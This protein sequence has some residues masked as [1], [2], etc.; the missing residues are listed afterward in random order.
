MRNEKKIIVQTAIR[1]S[2]KD[3]LEQL[4]AKKGM[5]Q[6]S[7][8]SRLVDWFA[9]QDSM[10]Q[11]LILERVEE[12]DQVQIAKLIL[13]RIIGKRTSPPPKHRKSKR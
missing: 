1:G 3:Q 5:T 2:T 4:C 10:V 13:S 8:F 6:I 9:E 12:V 11:T 7:L